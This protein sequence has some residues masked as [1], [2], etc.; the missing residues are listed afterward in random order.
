[1]REKEENSKLIIIPTYNESA[2]IVDLIDKIRGLAPD[3][4]IL[5]VDDNSPDETGKIIDK[6]SAEEPHIKCLHRPQ[7]RGIGPAYIDGFKWALSKNYG[8]IL[9]MDADFS[10]NPEYIPVLFETARAHDL[11][12]GS[13]YTLGG[14]IENWN[15]LRKFVSRFG[16]FYSKVM[17][18]LP[19]N[20][21]TGGFK[22][23][24]SSTLK[25]I[26]LDKILTRGYAFQI[27]TTYRA[28][29]NGAS[30]KEIPII[31]IDRREGQTKM[32]WSIFFE[33]IF[34]VLKLRFL[35]QPKIICQP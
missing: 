18:N 2:V 8:Y 5:I 16:S 32:T 34:G 6:I 26:E 11:V 25:K 15:I 22:C 7:K 17:L 30:I 4:D 1:M 28:F 13:R 14:K 33:A 27:E 9:Q 20:D 24:K 31:F 19:I 3:A 10:H 23:F 35:K 29:Q 12:I 21:L